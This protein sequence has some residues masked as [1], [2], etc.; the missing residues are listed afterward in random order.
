M[1]PADK[2]ILYKIFSGEKMLY[3]A[4][5]SWK[6]HQSELQTQPESPN[7]V[8]YL[9]DNTW[10]L[11]RWIRQIGLAYWEQKTELRRLE[12]KEKEEG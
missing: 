12:A 1:P 8:V 11:K 10:W 3:I 7:A 6:K 4:E 5:E 2:V 9:G